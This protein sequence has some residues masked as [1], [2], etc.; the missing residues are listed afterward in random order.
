MDKFYPYAIIIGIPNA[1]SMGMCRSLGK[2]NIPI[3]FINID[4]TDPLKSK[5]FNKIANIPKHN[6]LSYL[7]ESSDKFNQKPVIFPGADD[8]ILLLD[9]NKKLLSNYYHL[10]GTDTISMKKLIHKGDFY[11]IAKSI[12]NLSL[13]KTICLSKNDFKGNSFDD[14]KFPCIIK[15]TMPAVIK[16]SE[17]KIV[18]NK[19]ESD[20]YIKDI[21]NIADECLI[22]EYIDGPDSNNHGVLCYRSAHIDRSFFCMLKK[23][24]MYPPIIGTSSFVK[25][26][27]ISDRLSVGINE[28]LKSINFHGICDI[29]IKLKNNIYYIIEANY[30]AGETIY[31]STISGLNLPWIAYMDTLNKIPTDYYKES[32]K[33]IYWSNENYELKNYLN[34]IIS[35]KELMRS[36]FLSNGL[37]FNNFNDI[38]TTISYVKKI[39]TKK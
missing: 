17:Y 34:G 16:K 15:S 28:F 39:I 30:R 35:L 21:I 38:I 10:M 13:P 26:V 4:D 19:F 37:A 20:N 14:L 31:S 5:Y 36:L 1:T 3:I 24:R 32:K 9:E 27:N 25:T 22:Q 23:I 8:V 18:Y 7:L 6:I 11:Q 2:Y 29:D 12:G 33:D